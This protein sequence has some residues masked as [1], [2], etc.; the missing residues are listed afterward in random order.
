M[1]FPSMCVV[2]V[3]GGGGCRGL[4]SSW[5]E[6]LQIG[7]RAQ[8]PFLLGPLASAF[9]PH[10]CRSSQMFLLCCHMDLGKTKRAS[11]QFKAGESDFISPDS[12]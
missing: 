10:T 2:A 9:Y 12:S 8:W 11:G 1:S 7:G 4:G 5:G 6:V 3:Q